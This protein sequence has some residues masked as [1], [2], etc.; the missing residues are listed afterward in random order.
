MG[1]RRAGSGLDEYLDVVFVVAERADLGRD[2]GAGGA[3]G[4]VLDEHLFAADLGE[5]GDQAA[6]VP[7]VG[8]AAAVVDH[9]G[10]ESQGV[11]GNFGV[12]LEQRLE[13]GERGVQ[14]GVVELEL[15]NM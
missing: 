13:L 15:A 12:G 1:P 8:D 14:V 4:V 11:P 10:D 3:E 7:L 5:D 6:T 9:A 2:V